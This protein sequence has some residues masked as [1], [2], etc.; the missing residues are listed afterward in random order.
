MKSFQRKKEPIMNNLPVKYGRYGRTQWTL[1][2]FF[3]VLFRH[4][5]KVIGFFMGVFLTVAA[6]TFIMPTIYRSEAKLLVR[7][8]R[9]SVTA[10]PAAGIGQILQ[11]GQRRENEIKSEIE[12][13]DNR[14]LA[15]QLVDEFGPEKIYPP[16][17]FSSLPFFAR[18]EIKIKDRAV[19]HLMRNWDIKADRDSN[20]INITYDAESPQQAQELLKKHIEFYLDKHLKVHRSIGAEDFFK[21]QTEKIRQNL[22]ETE[23][24]LLNLRNDTGISAVETQR[25]N[26]LARLDLLQRDLAQTDADYKTTQ[27][28]VSSINSLLG[29]LPK[30]IVTQGTTGYPNIAAD[31]MRQKVFELQMKEQ[32]LL[33]KYTEKNYLVQEV[34]RQLKSAQ[35]VLVKEDTNRSQVTKAINPAYQ[36]MD[37]ALVAEKANLDALKAKGEALEQHLASL[38]EKM[39]GMNENTVQFARLQRELDIQEANYKKYSGQLEQARIEAALET[40]KISNISV[41]EAPTFSVKPVR[42]RRLLQLA[43][44]F[45]LGGCGAVGLAFLAEHLN[46]SFGRPEEVQRVLKLETLAVIPQLSDGKQA[47]K[48]QLMLIPP[49]TST[50]KN[51]ILRGGM[52][53]FESLRDEIILLD[54]KCDSP[55]PRFIAV[56]S[57]HSGEGV[58]M[59]AANLAET[60]A[61]HRNERVLLVEMNHFKPMAHQVFGIDQMQG[62][63]N[64]VVAEGDASPISEAQPPTPPSEGQTPTGNLEVIPYGYGDIPLS[65]LLDSKQF[66]NLMDLWKMS[67]SYV[68]FDTAPIFDSHSTLNMAC[69]ANGVILVVGAEETSWEATRKAVHKLKR[70]QANLLGVVLNKRQYHIPDWIYK[71]L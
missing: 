9:E 35:G 66:L 36:Q 62:L 28:K 24:T 17:M 50:D 46:H 39:K 31:G 42:P 38:R 19:R 21:Q 45:L 51:C 15:E 44:G 48:N 65:Q 63:T 60:L 43:L 18:S 16:S 10:D 33:S 14:D 59:V 30:T 26:M 68:I 54:E 71:R 34:R 56:T 8:G 13:L 53:A 58:S 22:S 32:E 41:V 61:R 20:I 69:L 40:G 47:S 55:P 67:Y 52:E 2:D 25:T 29:I 5:R 1:K 3:Y 12:L 70:C 57:C 27:A 11:I 6:I 4:K 7:V 37:N 23:K 64:L 49:A